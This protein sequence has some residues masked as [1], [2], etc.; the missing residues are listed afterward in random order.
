MEEKAGLFS[1]NFGIH[2]QPAKL[3]LGINTYMHCWF[4]LAG[5]LAD[6]D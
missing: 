3:N 1:L 4:P 6:S 5:M 2:L